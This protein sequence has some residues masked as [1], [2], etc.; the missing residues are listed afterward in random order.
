MSARVLSLA[1]PLTILLTLLILFGNAPAAFAQ[2]II[3]DFPPTG[4][5]LVIGGPVSIDLH[6]VDAVVDGPVATVH[7]T[8]VF[9]NQADWEVEGSYIFPLPSNAA[10][11]DFQMTVDGQVL[12]GELLP[13]DEARRIYEDIVRQRRDPA[14]LEYVGRDLFQTSV[15]P[16]PPGAVRKLEL[17]YTQVLGLE[18]GLYHFRYP[19]QTR[20]YSAAPVKS[21]ALRVELR[22]QPGLRTVYS[23]SHDVSIERTGDDSALVGY[24]AGETQPAQDFDLY[25]GVSKDA[26]GLNLLSYKP[27]GE[28]GFFLL[29]AAPG[30]DVGADEVV[31]RDIIL[32]MDVSGS[33]EGEKVAQAQE[34]ARY[35]VDHLNPG[36]RFN[37][38][39]FSTGVR[40]WAETLTPFDTKARADAH[41]WIDTL[42]AEGSTDINRAL[43]EALAQLSSDEARP[44]Y[45][46]FMTDGLPTQ[47]ETDPGRILTNAQENLPKPRTVRLFTFGVGYDVDT[48]LLDQLSGS[49]GGRSTYVKPGERIDEAISSFYSRISTPVLSNVSVEFDGVRAED[50]YPYPLPDLFAGEQLVWAGRYRRGGDTTVTL[51]GVVNGQERV[52]RYPDQRLVNSGGEPAVARLWATRKIG[53]LLEQVRR[54]GANQELIDAIVELSTAYGIVTP[55]TSYLV[56]EPQLRATMPDM[57]IQEAP[58]ALPMPRRVQATVAV[59][60]LAQA[61][62]SGADAVAASETRSSFLSAERVVE[63]EGV[64]FVAGKTF[65]LQG[66]STTEDGQTQELWVDNQFAETAPLETVPFGSDAYFAL[67]ARARRRSMAGPIAGDGGRHRRQSL[68]HHYHGRGDANAWSHTNAGS[69][70]HPDIFP[71]PHTDAYPDDRRPRPARGNNSWPGYAVSLASPPPPHLPQYP[72]MM[73]PHGLELPGQSGV[74]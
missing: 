45:V 23:S 63:H 13:K 17:S 68:S 69:N 20:Q 57:G 5:V 31:Q 4:R 51:T 59:E 44:A 58:T 50:A 29:L 21:L 72:A 43:L 37:L 26:I 2:G 27:A 65:T 62:A 73:R 16:I 49:L 54:Q 22:N 60:A 70:P 41:A 9:R 67:T 28:D 61:P 1:R 11:S 18:N 30:I 33:M 42:R 36:D 48:D 74:I 52:F 35:L 12:E 25:F 7:V 71:R 64:R 19:L 15:F 10:V 66:V 6:S 38:V 32:V 47:G 40:L 34:A 56:L 3:V 8:Q 55:Y 53:A 39:A 14:L 24:E 46:L